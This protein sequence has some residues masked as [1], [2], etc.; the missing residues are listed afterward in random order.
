M[1]TLIHILVVDDEPAIRTLLR[2]GLEPEGFTVWDAGG[3]AALMERL[4]TG[5]VDLITLD[6][7]L[8]GQDGLALAHR[9]RTSYNVP[10]IMITSRVTIEDRIIGLE[11]GA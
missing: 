3:E 1:G 6:L 7:N 8:G 10:I 9:I 4:E 2:Q 11:N 5:P